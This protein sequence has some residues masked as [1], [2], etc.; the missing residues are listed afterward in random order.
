MDTKKKGGGQGK[1]ETGFETSRQ[2]STASGNKG[3]TGSVEL[4]GSSSTEK[5][6][7]VFTLDCSGSDKACSFKTT[8][9]FEDVLKKGVEHGKARHGMTGSDAKIADEIKPYIIKEEKPE[10]LAT[11]EKKGVRSEEEVS[12]ESSNQARST[13]VGGGYPG[14]YQGPPA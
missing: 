3:L 5:K 8:G 9:K 14:G 6:S 11:E 13:G 1:S 10:R 2:T 4:S 12:D 7:G